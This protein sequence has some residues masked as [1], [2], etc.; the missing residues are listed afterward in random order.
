MI[1]NSYGKNEWTFPGGGIKKNET[2]EA[3]AKR[4]VS[5]EVGI[6]IQDIKPIGEFISE[7]EYKKD[8]IFCFSAEVNNK[9]FVIQESEILE[10]K[11]FSSINLPNNISSIAVRVLKFWK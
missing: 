4:E 1:R 8:R 3:A 10:A 7:L 9:N 5:E 11:W 2:P 6:S